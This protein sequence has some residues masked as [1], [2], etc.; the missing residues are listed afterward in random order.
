MYTNL[1]LL[2]LERICTLKC[3]WEWVLFGLWKSFLDSYTQ[4]VL[5]DLL[6]NE[7]N[8]ITLQN[9]NLSGDIGLKY[10]PISFVSVK[11]SFC[12]IFFDIINTLQG[13]WVFIIFV[14]KKEIFQLIMK[15]AG[16]DSMHGVSGTGKSK[17]AIQVWQ[18]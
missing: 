14:C 18:F 1:F 10:Y 17:S 7:H 6:G 2:I 5:I 12:R 11:L 9:I 15:S 8:C 13:L 4:I 16:V 3:S